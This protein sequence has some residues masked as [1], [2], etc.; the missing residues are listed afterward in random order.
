MP[1]DE[2]ADLLAIRLASLNQIL[3]P[4]VYL[5]FRRRLAAVLYSAC[6]T[7]SPLQNLSSLKA[8]RSEFGQNSPKNSPALKHHSSA[9]GLYSSARRGLGEGKNDSRASLA[10]N[11]RS[12]PDGRCSLAANGRGEEKNGCGTCS[13]AVVGDS[14]NGGY[15]PAGRGLQEGADSAE[16]CLAPNA[17]C[18]SSSAA[19]ELPKDGCTSRTSVVAV[20][21]ADR[22]GLW[23]V[24]ADK[25]D[26]ERDFTN[27]SLQE[28]DASS[29]HCSLEAG[30]GADRDGLLSVE[31]NKVDVEKD[32][33]NVSLQEA[34]ASSGHCSLEAGAGEGDGKRRNSREGSSR[35]LTEDCSDGHSCLDVE[36]PL[37]GVISGAVSDGNITEP[38]VKGCPHE[39]ERNT[40][41]DILCD[42]IHSCEDSRNDQNSKTSHNGINAHNGSPVRLDI[43][44]TAGKS[45]AGEMSS[46]LTSCT[47][48]PAIYR[49][50]NQTVTKVD[51]AN[52]D[53]QENGECLP[54][55]N[56]QYSHVEKPSNH[57]KRASWSLNYV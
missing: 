50:G 35:P 12:P 9:N 41:N 37:P 17:E 57:F 32:F 28:A 47:S 7:V 25:V 18:F 27:V 26:V 11:D 5:L 54:L 36:E 42:N 48:C 19:S 10:L 56:N 2:G 15:S 22:D 53:D 13:L 40:C 6:K 52:K 49:H 3:D 34:D 23:S 31:A 38:G 39:N 24:E 30:G 45:S 29:G 8:M 14:P 4:W 33:T 21:F 51:H 20:R 55:L 46:K 1:V 44:G 16:S 43:V